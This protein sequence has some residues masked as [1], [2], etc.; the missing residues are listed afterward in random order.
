[1]QRRFLMFITIVLIGLAALTAGTIAQRNSKLDAPAPE[2][3][4]QWEYLIVSG[5]STNLS[6]GSLA[7]KQPDGSFAQEAVALQANFDK[8]GAKGWELV[9]VSGDPAGP[10]TAAVYYFKRLKR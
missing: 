3:A 6:S 10:R 5:G 2:I 7:R 1:M 4:D 8:L 9:S